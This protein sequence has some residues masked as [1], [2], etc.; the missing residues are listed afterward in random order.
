MLN[1]YLKQPKLLALWGVVLLFSL[2]SA[3]GWSWLYERT[4]QQVFAQKLREAQIANGA[5][6]EHTIQ[7]FQNVD[8]TL[9]A[10]RDVYERTHSVAETERFIGNLLLNTPIISKIYL[11]DRDGRVIIS[12]NPAMRGADVSD[13]EYFTFHRQSDRDVMHIDS[14]KAEPLDGEFL[15]RVTRRMAGPDGAFD[16]VALVALRPQAFSDF[17][18]RLNDDADGLTSLVG[19]DDRLIRARTPEPAPEVW[20][21]PLRRS[22]REMIAANPDGH[23]HA[24]SSLDGIQREFVYQRVGN[25]PLLLVSAYSDEDVARTVGQ[26]I[27]PITV[28]AVAG[29]L[30]SVILAG[31]L[32]TVLHQREEMKHLVTVDVLTGLFS[33][34][35]FM[36]LAE[37]EL[38]RS[39]RYSAQLSVLMIDIDHFK[40][41]NDTHGHQ[42]GDQVLREL[43]AILCK[44]LR[45]VDFV[46][47]L[48]GEE[49]A[50][51]LPQTD[52]LQAFEVAE[53]LRR[54]VE[55][56][57]IAISS[58][59]LL[60]ITISIG[61]CSLHSRRCSIDTLLGQADQALYDAKRL[62]RNQVSVHEIA[63]SLESSLSVA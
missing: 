50:A 18:R 20:Q 26:Q 43:G 45:E 19:L 47:R 8:V 37:R 55:V 24:K 10:V 30:S 49:F 34:R 17:F 42:V 54:T 31:I 13:L 14:V 62:G 60:R 56:S 3:I 58:S 48:G 6:V 32:T 5:F 22:M 61:V 35:H 7:V 25:L 9:S 16:G 63:A 41:I 51:I 36:V 11:V 52:V 57:D 29:V 12:R 4:R 15:F 21:M 44:A 39:L 53:R 2:A 23:S 1:K 28:A 40:R 33:R 59:A 46:G 27:T 38:H